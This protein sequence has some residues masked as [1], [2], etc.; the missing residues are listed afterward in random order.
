V[1]ADDAGGP[2]VLGLGIDNLRVVHRQQQAQLDSFAV[3]VVGT[4][5]CQVKDLWRPIYQNRELSARNV[6]PERQSPSLS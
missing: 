4:V 2:G 3:Q 6:D 1:D 5:R